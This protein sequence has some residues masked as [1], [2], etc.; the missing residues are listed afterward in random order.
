MFQLCLPNMLAAMRFLLEPLGSRKDSL[1]LTRQCLEEH[2]R[3]R[4]RCN[5]VATNA[6]PSHGLQ[7]ALA[8]GCKPWTS[9]HGRWLEPS[10]AI[11]I[12]MTSDCCIVKAGASVGR[13][14]PSS[15]RLDLRR[16]LQPFLLQSRSTRHQ[17]VSSI[18]VT[19]SLVIPVWGYH[20]QVRVCQLPC[21]LMPGVA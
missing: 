9:S 3:D 18:R 5:A 2:W 12:G 4:R 11:K 16:C 20:G 14:R 19:I 10:C 17:L 7:R 6:W 21:A 15:V 1:D 8:C 13:K